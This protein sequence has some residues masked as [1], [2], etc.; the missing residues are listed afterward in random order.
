MV[1][2]IVKKL[3]GFELKILT[4]IMMMKLKEAYLV[5]HAYFYLH[6]IFFLVAIFHNVVPFLQYNKTPIYLRSVNEDQFFEL[7]SESLELNT[8][9]QKREYL[10]LFDSKNCRSKVY[11]KLLI[12]THLVQN[13]FQTV[14]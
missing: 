10:C 1:G 3:K 6:V 14:I 13:N 9:K 5:I 7:K 12:F 2:I 8:L 4:H 11:M